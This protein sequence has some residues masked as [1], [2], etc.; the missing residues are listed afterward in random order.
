MKNTLSKLQ[1]FIAFALFPFASRLFLIFS[2]VEGQLS[3]LGTGFLADIYWSFLLTV[4][5]VVLLRCRLWAVIPLIFLWAVTYAVDVEHIAAL[6]GMAH[7]SNIQYLFDRQFLVNSMSAL[8]LT[9]LLATGGLMA[10]ALWLLITGSRSFRGRLGSRTT[11]PYL[12]ILVLSLVVGGGGAILY[13]VTPAKTIATLS[14]H[15]RNFFAYHLDAIAA[16]VMSAVNPRVQPQ[17]VVV[18]DSSRQLLFSSDLEA[19]RPALGAA[20][21]VLLIV[22]EGLSGGYLEP[23]ANVM[24][25]SVKLLSS[26]GAWPMPQ[27]SKLA[28]QSLIIPNFI[29]HRRETLRGLYSILCSDFPKLDNSMPKPLEILSNSRAADRCLP[30]LLREKGYSTHYFQA[31]NLQFM[32]KDTVM[33]FIGFEDVRGKEAFALPEDYYFDW[34]PDDRDF[35]AQTVDWLDTIEQQE[36][37]W[38][39]TLLTVGTHH[40]YAVRDGEGGNNA[41]IA[42]VAA[43]DRALA[44]LLTHLKESGIADNT[45]ILITSD[46]SHGIPGQQFSNNLGMMLAL[47]PDLAPD[48]SDDV[49]STADVTL[50]IMDYLNFQSPLKN[51]TGRSFF[52]D[53]SQERTMLFSQWNT[54]SMSTQKGQIISCPMLELSF[55]QWV[56]GDG[57]CEKFLSDNGQMFA[58]GYQHSVLVEPQPQLYQLQVM[59]DARLREQSDNATQHISLGNNKKVVLHRDSWRELSVGQLMN[60]EKGT[61]VTLELDISYTAADQSIM[62]LSFETSDLKSSKTGKSF[63][64]VLTSFY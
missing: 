22:M 32:S 50:S 17:K 37:P 43:A 2:G 31:A 27:L 61:L 45:L 56:L 49:F 4:I 41:K 14:W 39:A 7:H 19:P 18:E 9:K 57:H 16:E 48:K 34:G 42:A 25:T 63:L 46:E 11:G 8:S 36:Q 47:A 58:K 6:G 59:M 23:V 24:G 30:R 38:F 1:L 5:S 40:P 62:E 53:Y 28:E 64:P 26:T 15:N 10:L 21:N 13:S 60:F 20:R 35:F 3:S 12:A 33:P 44:T 54:V 52:R 51:L 29:T 55:L